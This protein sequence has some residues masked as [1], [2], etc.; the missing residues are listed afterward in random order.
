MIDQRGCT[1]AYDYDLLGRPTHDRVLDLGAGAVGPVRR[2]STIYDTRGMV[3][4]VTSWDDPR[5]GLGNVLNQVQNVYNDFGQQTHSYQEH[6]G[7]VNTSTSP[8]PS[9][10]VFVRQRIGPMG[11]AVKDSCQE[12]ACSLQ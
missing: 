8:K 2:L 7:V 10:P 3:E 5:I 4:K 9:I 6:G 11:N 12:K 1:H